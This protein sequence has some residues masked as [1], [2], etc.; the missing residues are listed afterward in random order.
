M[1]CEMV[2]AAMIAASAGARAESSSEEPGAL[3]GSW[4]AEIY[5]M[6]DG[7]RHTVDGLIFF[8]RR[9]WSVVFF[10]LPGEGPPSRGAAEAGTYTVSGDRLVLTHLYH[11]S[12]GR[13]ATGLP[14]VPLRMEV[15]P[16]AAAPTEPCVYQVNGD[17][18][19]IQFPT[20]N[21]MMFRRSGRL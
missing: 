14:E 10:L 20:G 18:L 4:R 1:L 7:V 5:I 16:A 15:N 21:V 8:T 19:R 12:S 13:A 2:V 3:L 11:L 6:K 9:D 17:R